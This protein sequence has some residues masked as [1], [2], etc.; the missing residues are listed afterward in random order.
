MQT[1]LTIVVMLLS[2]PAGLLC[3]FFT[4]DEKDI[5]RWY[6]PAFAWVLAALTAVFLSVN[7]IYAMTTLFMLLIVLVWMNGKGIT[8]LCKQP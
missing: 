6:F 1:L 4:K 7:L 2:I 8:S 5:Y 3:Y